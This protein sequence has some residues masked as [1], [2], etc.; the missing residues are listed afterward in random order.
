MKANS[1]IFKNSQQA[2]EFFNEYFFTRSKEILAKG[3]NRNGGELEQFNVFIWINKPKVKKNIDFGNYFGYKPQKWINLINNYIDINLL[4]S[5]KVQVIDKELKKSKAYNISM[6]CSNHH[7]HGKGCL[8]SMTFSRRHNSDRPCITLHTRA[9]EVTKR[10]LLDLLLIQRVGEYVYG[11]NKF[12][13]SMFTIKIY[14][15]AESFSMYN[16]HIPIKELGE[17]RADD[18]WQE[19][20]LTILNK[21]LT[22]NIDDIKYKVHKRSVRQLQRDKEGN[23]LS[24]NHPMLTKDLLFLPVKGVEYTETENEAFAK[25]IMKMKNLS[26]TII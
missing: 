2:W 25:R 15:N 24:G 5:A 8:L 3:G 11:H 10:M 21:F 6:K 17:V 9:T 7:G 26:N 18:A 16:N 20:C 23:P 14:Q 12:N 19:R 22:C 13:I 1:F 4:E